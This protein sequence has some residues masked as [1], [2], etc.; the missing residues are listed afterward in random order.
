MIKYVCLWLLLI[1]PAAASV[2]VR[3]PGGG[4]TA[5]VTVS[6]GAVLWSVRFRGAPVIDPAPIGLV[7]ADNPSA[8]LAVGSITRTTRD[9]RVTGLIGKTSTARDQYREATIRFA[10]ASGRPALD[11]IVRA[12]DDGAAYRWAVRSQRPFRLMVER[13]DFGMPDTAQAWAMPVKGFDSS[14][15]EY[16][17]SGPLARTLPHGQLIAL[18][19][20][21]HRGPVWAAITEAALH[22]WAGLYLT[23]RGGAPGM[24]SRLSPRLDDPG[25]IVRGHAGV[26]LSRWRLVIVGDAP[27]RLV[28]SNL[29]TVLNPPPTVKDW[30]WVKPGKTVFPWWNDYYW[31]GAPFKPGLNTATY[32]A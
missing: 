8:P 19:L 1:G 25:M 29:V 24:S 16:Y 7:F 10:A 20:L 27:G 6:G 14:Y 30:S 12:Y 31:P 2:L 13:A 5:V 15:E 9:L 21:F 11:F 4:A 23:R 18:P 28:E 3:S 32:L 22:D 17:R 26:H